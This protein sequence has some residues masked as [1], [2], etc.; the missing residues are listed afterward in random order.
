MCGKGTHRR[1]TDAEKAE[2]K[3]QYEG[4]AASGRK[5]VVGEW[6]QGEQMEGSTEEEVEGSIE[7]EAT[8]GLQPGDWDSDEGS[9]EATI[10]EKAARLQVRRL[11]AACG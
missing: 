3:K 8:P 5:F 10:S 4:N 6:D 9:E 7:E 11:F 1:A 2:T